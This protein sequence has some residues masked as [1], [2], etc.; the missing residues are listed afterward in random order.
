MAELDHLHSIG[1][2][3]DDMLTEMRQA[4]QSGVRAEDIDK[5]LHAL[6]HNH[7]KRRRQEVATPYRR[8]VQICT[9][10]CGCMGWRHRFDRYCSVCGGLQV[11]RDR[12]E[13]RENSILTCLRVS[14]RQPACTAAQPLARRSLS[15]PHHH[16]HSTSCKLPFAERSGCH[17]TP[18]SA[19]PSRAPL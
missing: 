12:K 1:I 19:V 13:G 2:L 16:L 11:D 5:R 7:A 6:M 9:R 3:A 10:S 18:C 17:T 8:D 15:D 14:R 4:C